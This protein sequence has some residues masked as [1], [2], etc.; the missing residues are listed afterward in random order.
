MTVSID[1]LTVVIPAFNEAGKIGD[2]LADLRVKIPGVQVLVVD[3]GSRDATVQI[4]RKAGA[5]VISHRKNKGYGAAL[6]TGFRTARTPY[7]AMCDA[8]GQHRPE[9]LALMLQYA[10][11]FDMVIGARGKNSHRSAVRRP[12][13]WLLCKL[14][15]VLVRQ[16][17]PDLNSG[18]RVMRREVILRYLHLLPDGFSA[19][20]TST[21]CVLHRGYEVKFMRITTGKR[22]GHSTVRQARDGLNS[23]FLMVRLIVL[24]NPR[25]VFL[26][27]ALVLVVCGLLYGLNTAML[28]GKGF[29]T[30]AVLAVMT[31]L[32]TGMFGL[33]ADQI[34]SLRLELFERDLH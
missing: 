24:F 28:V 19:S 30:L 22:F 15:N 34:S 26:P 25:R 5:A 2:V 29:P 16:R 21:L 9:D 6:K 23:V 18:L 4:A 8:D 10:D 32:I 11:G 13:K 31:G 12:G 20:T 7:L 3:D 1:Q 17:I 33:I 14:A 27:P